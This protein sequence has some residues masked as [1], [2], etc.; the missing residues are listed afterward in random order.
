MELSTPPSVLL[1]V[2]KIK[3]QWR[4]LPV[5]FPHLRLS[6]TFLFLGNYFIFSYLNWMNQCSESVLS[7]LFPFLSYFDL[8]CGL[9]DFIIKEFILGDSSILYFLNFCL[10]DSHSSPSLPLPASDV[11]SPQV[12]F[13]FAFH[14]SRGPAMWNGKSWWSGQTAVPLC[15]LSKIPSRTILAPVDYISGNLFLGFQK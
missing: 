9:L 12:I 3:I 14:V 8:S 7:W 4:I 13:W 2:H 1:Y 6:V 15:V 10:P 5:P 11:C